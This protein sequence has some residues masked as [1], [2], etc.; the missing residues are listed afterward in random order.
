MT[1][2][3]LCSESKNGSNDLRL[4]RF[5]LPDSYPLCSGR[6]YLQKKNE[7][8]D[9]ENARNGKKDGKENFERKTLT[10]RVIGKGYQEKF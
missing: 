9:L 1:Q 5:M 8:V 10:V 4:F 7:S 3:I 2:R 6:K